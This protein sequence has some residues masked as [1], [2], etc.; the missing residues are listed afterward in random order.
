MAEIN[1]IIPSKI[2]VVGTGVRYDLADGQHA[3]NLNYH[4]STFMDYY[5][6][7][8]FIVPER[9]F[10]MFFDGLINEGVRNHKFQNYFDLNVSVLVSHLRKS[11]G[12]S[13]SFRKTIH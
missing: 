1:S 10:R 9:M 8:Q 3:Y 6:F 13:D 5:T 11:H 7:D 4:E 12:Y 2:V